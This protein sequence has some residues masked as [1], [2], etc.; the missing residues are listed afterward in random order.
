MECAWHRLLHEVQTKPVT[1][2]GEDFVM[3]LL[4]AWELL[5]LWD[6]GGENTDFARALHSGA[7]LT[8]ACLTKDGK[9]VFSSAEEVLK[10]LSAEEINGIVAAYQA[11]SRRADP[12]VDA[13]EETVE[14]LKKA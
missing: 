6:D 4:S 12:G 14:A 11:W 8:A 3:R 1:L 10:T 7:A 2:R 9:T 13:S 5:M